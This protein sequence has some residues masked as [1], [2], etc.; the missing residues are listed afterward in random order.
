MFGGVGMRVVEH[1]K[2]NTCCE[3]SGEA[4]LG[5]DCPSAR[6][7]G[8]LSDQIVRVNVKRRC[9]AAQGRLR[10]GGVRSAWI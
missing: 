9:P 8:R 1:A 3:S 2:E 7:T 6:R 5:V 10:S 4:R